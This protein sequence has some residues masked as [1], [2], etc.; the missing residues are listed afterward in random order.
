MTEDTSERNGST[1]NET[2]IAPRR[3]SVLQGIAALGLGSSAIGTAVAQSGDRDDSSERNGPPRVPVAIQLY[4][5]RNLPDTTLEL[6]RRVGSVD[7][8]GGPGYDAVEFAGLGDASTSEINTTLEKT[9][10]GAASAHVGLETLEGNSFEDT[11]RTYT[12]IGVDTFVV[13]SVSS[14]T[15]STVENVQKLAQRMN[16]VADR[17]E[18]Y[19]GRVGFHNHDAAFQT[20]ED[21]RTALDVFNE[22]LNEGVIFEIDVGWVLTAGYDPAE[23]IRAYSDRT[24]L[25]HMKDMKDGNFAEIGEGAVDIQEV[26]RVARREANVDYL[27]Y[28]HDQPQNPAESVGTGAGVLSFIDGQPRRKCLKFEDVGGPDY[29]GDLSSDHRETDE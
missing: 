15:L 5:L 25:I 13:P 9:G 10:V 22:N 1:A 17:L 19:D 27:V 16:G 12:E 4:T 28:E 2:S 23:I 20:L 3:R 7:N 18:D 21:G 24:E 6:I 26:A 29:N 8:N 14:S 11:A